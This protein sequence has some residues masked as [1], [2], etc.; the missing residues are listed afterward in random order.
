M[1]GANGSLFK[2]QGA[3]RFL[4]SVDLNKSTPRLNEPIRIGVYESNNMRKRYFLSL[5]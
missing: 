2:S 5:F 4:N 3:S 1:V